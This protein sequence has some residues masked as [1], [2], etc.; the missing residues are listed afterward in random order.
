MHLPPHIWSVIIPPRL[1][2]IRAPNELFL[3]LSA[4]QQNITNAT[5]LDGLGKLLLIELF[6]GG[7]L[8][9]YAVPADFYCVKPLPS[10]AVVAVAYRFFF[11]LSHCTPLF[12]SCTIVFCVQRC[13]T[14]TLLPGPA[15]CST[16]T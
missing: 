14:I 5:N 16:A 11:G 9:C 3:R 15:L 10:V 1:K 12:A 2:L 8:L 7:L 6:P 4:H 13:Q